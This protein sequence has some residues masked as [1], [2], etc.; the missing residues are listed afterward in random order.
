[1]RIQENALGD[2]HP[3][4]VQT[5]TDLAICR[6]DLGETHKGKPLLERALVLQKQQ[7]GDTHADVLAIEEVLLSLS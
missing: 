5:L 2:D 3:S 7:L 1:L 4:S 6:L